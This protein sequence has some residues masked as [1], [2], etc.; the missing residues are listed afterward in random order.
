V[1]IGGTSPGAVRDEEVR[2]GDWVDEEI[3]EGEV[4]VGKIMKKGYFGVPKKTNG[5]NSRTPCA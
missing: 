3:K 4:K 2:G 5:W 1:K